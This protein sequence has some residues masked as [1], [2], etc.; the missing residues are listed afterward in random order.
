MCWDETKL[1]DVWLRRDPHEERIE[2]TQIDKKD[3]RTTSQVFKP[4]RVP[5]L[6]CGWNGSGR[7]PA[8]AE[9]AWTVVLNL[10][11]RADLLT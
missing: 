8:A 11:V 7:F 5:L 1:Y 10:F 6:A 9:E 3:R 2:T 4:G